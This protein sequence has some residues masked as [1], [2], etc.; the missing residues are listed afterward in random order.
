MDPNRLMGFLEIAHLMGLI[1]YMH[2][3]CIKKKKTFGK[4]RVIYYII[5]W[6][7]PFSIAVTLINQINPVE[8]GILIQFTGGIYMAL[9]IFDFG[10]YYFARWAYPRFPSIRQMIDRL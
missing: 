1:L 10:I 6:V 9:I 8:Y 5:A 2:H 7:L 3:I 4:K